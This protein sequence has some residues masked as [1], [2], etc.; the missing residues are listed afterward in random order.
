MGD[1]S[2]HT[3]KSQLTWQKE[4]LVYFFITRVTLSILPNVRYSLVHGH[5]PNPGLSPSP[6]DSNT[7]Y[8]IT[9]ED[10]DPGICL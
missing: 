5:F 10:L 4:S 9:P 8:Q 3:H 1:S 2:Y 7:A 6:W